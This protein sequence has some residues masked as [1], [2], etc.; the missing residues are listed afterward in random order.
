MIKAEHLSRSYGSF[1]AVADVSFEVPDGQI[2]GLLGPN[3][4]GKTTLMRIL[5]GYHLPSAGGAWIN[6][7]DVLRQTQEAQKLIGYL[8]E[9]PPLYPELTVEEYLQFAAEARQIPRPQEA[10]DRAV[11]LTGLEPMYYKTIGHLSKGYR[12]RTGL[13][14]AILH[15]PAILILDEP[16]SGLDPN[17]ILDFRSLIR[18]L[19]QKK[20]VILSTHI[21]QEVEALCERVLILHEGKIRADGSVEEI[22]RGLEGLN[23]YTAVVKGLGLEA[24]ASLE[25]LPLWK[26]KPRVLPHAVGIEIHAACSAEVD[27]G[28]ALFDWVV[29]HGGKL[30]S[31]VPETFNLENIF[32]QLTREEKK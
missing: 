16:T 3:G 1:V 7:V 23:R 29:A 9:T 6:G 28:E 5:T 21:L 4:A 17:Q 14:Q 25:K 22:A 24:A 8:P 13:A 31:L 10:I 32:S 11:N 18:T 19:G 2:V 30:V 15:D 20:T 26:E 12:Q 27:G